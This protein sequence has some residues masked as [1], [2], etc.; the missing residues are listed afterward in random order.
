MIDKETVNCT[1]CSACYSA[2]PQDSIVMK[3]D[4]YGF[5]HPVVDYQKCISCSTCLRVCPDISLGKRQISSHRLFA[6]KNNS[7]NDRL[8]S[9][10]GGVF[11][12][13]AQCILSMGG[14]VFGAAFDC[15]SLSVKHIEAQ[16]SDALRPIR[17][18]K[19]VQSEIR[20][21]YTR[22]I[23]LLS[24]SDKPILFSGTP[25][26]VAGLK[27]LINE[28]DFPNL[29]TVDTFCHGVGSPFIFKSYLEH[30]MKLHNSR[31]THVNFRDKKHGWRDYSLKIEFD[32]GQKYQKK[33]SKDYFMRGYLSNL[34]L[35]DSCYSCK[36]KASN[37]FSD[38]TL[39]DFWGIENEFPEFDDNKGVSL[40]I[41]HTDKG[42]K[43]L[44]SIRNNISVI[45]INDLAVLEKYN[46]ASRNSAKYPA[47]REQFLSESS[48]YDV[49]DVLKRYVP[50]HI[51]SELIDETK[52]MIK[53]LIKR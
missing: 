41:A 48:I 12:N 32:N 45:E 25:C 31:I 2:C 46:S 52:A 42:L 14:S 51:I 28:K 7:T 18:S 49:Y 44:N 10:S 23:Q 35:R 30:F 47:N 3:P 16:N 17:G 9:S 22:V 53:K 5:F 6:I 40:V 36:Y 19:Y 27:S 11:S 33:K 21:A 8:E 29:L 37:R 24:S 15:D 38:L 26:Q 4:S 1:G 20:S 13:L 34:F 43:Y 50:R 39:A